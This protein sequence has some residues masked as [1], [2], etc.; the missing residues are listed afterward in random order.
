MNFSE[1]FSTFC[2]QVDKEPTLPDTVT[3]APP[4]CCEQLYNLYR[5][6]LPE[7]LEE[8]KPV[9]FSVTKAE[10][11]LLIRDKLRARETNGRL[12]FYDFKKVNATR[13][14]MSPYYNDVPAM[15]PQPRYE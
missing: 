7:G 4:P 13:N 11:L 15:I 8:P 5:T 10:G 3:P 1:R 12:I 9:V 6:V 14:E 2:R